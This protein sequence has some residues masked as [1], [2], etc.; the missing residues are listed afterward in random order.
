M[1]ASAIP[2]L[3]PSDFG[4][5]RLRSGE[6]MSIRPIRPDDEQKMLRFHQTLSESSVYSRYFGVMKLETRTAHERLAR[7]CSSDADRRL[8]LVAERPP[9]E[10]GSGEIGAVARLVRI[11]GDRDAEFALLVSDALQG[12]G[13]GR[14][15]LI[16]LVAVARDWDVEHIVA[17]ILPDNE[18]MRALCASLGFSF[19]GNTG[20][21]RDLR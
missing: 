21:T 15:L 20:A 9:R 6:V 13:L 4:N 11:A 10:S 19:R 16:R 18:R 2:P 3:P 12:Q 14:A 1:I 8:V 7:I 17:E 5:V